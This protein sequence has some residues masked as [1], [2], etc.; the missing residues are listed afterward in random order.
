MRKSKT[1]AKLRSGDVPRVTGL[2]SYN[3]AWVRHAAANGFDCIWLDTE[4]RA[5]DLTQVYSMLALSHMVDIDIMVR[6]PTRQKIELYRYLEEGATGLMIPHVTTVAEA[7]DLAQSV[8]FP[9]IGNRGIDGAGLDADYYLDDANDYVLNANRETFL[10]VQIESPEALSNAEAIAAVDG[11]DIL[12]LGPAD[13]QLRAKLLPGTPDLAAAEVQ[14][15]AAV[16]KQGKHWGRPGG[17][18]AMLDELYAKG[19]RFVS[20]GS[21]FGAMMAMLKQASDDFDGAIA[22]IR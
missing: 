6:T 18:R 2:G 10:A 7:E 22:E 21:D 19:A 9:P 5:I 8:R 1:L 12:F 11:V 20:A 15:A 13:Y 14:L 4:H 16:A 3:P 17:G